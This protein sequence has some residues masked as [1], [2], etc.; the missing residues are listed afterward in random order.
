MAKCQLRQKR[1]K[2]ILFRPCSNEILGT[3]HYITANL[4]KVSQFITL[5]FIYTLI[6]G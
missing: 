5:S 4:K 2:I 3:N 6:F 1:K